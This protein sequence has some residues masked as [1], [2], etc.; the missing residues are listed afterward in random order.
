MWPCPYLADARRHDLKSG[1]IAFAVVRG[2]FAHD[3]RETR[4]ERPQRHTPDLD[5]GIGDRHA[6]AQ[7]RHCTLDTTSHQI[8][9]RGLAICCTELPREVRRRHQ[10]STGH[11]WHA[12]PLRVVAIHEVASAPQ[13]RKVSDLIGWHTFDDSALAAA[14]PVGVL[15]VRPA[16]Q[17]RRRPGSGS[18]RHSVLPPRRRLLR[19][20]SRLLR[21]HPG[22]RAEPCRQ[23]P[24]GIRRRAWPDVGL[25]HRIL[26][27]GPVGLAPVVNCARPGR[28][29]VPAI[30]RG[31]GGPTLVGRHIR[32]APSPIGSP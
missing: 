12:Q 9:I 13:M 10:R 22:W 3:L 16:D 31:R 28:R 24:I 6:A 21:L 32:S 18:R 4:T 29:V 20:G 5:T 30:G 27:A 2:C 14:L 15:P 25:R 1:V 23:H 11:R 26:D 7:Q 19:P 8:R 17:G